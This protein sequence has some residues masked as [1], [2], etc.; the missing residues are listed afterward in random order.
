MAYA[1]NLGFPRIGPNREL[2]KAVE[3]YWKGNSSQDDLLTVA[4][5]I[6]EQNW[7]LQ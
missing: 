7:R 3:S 2:K 6:R 1:A 5:A 4:K